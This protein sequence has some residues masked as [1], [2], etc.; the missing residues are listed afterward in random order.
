MIK[1]KVGDLIQ[2]A[3]H[4][5]VTVIAHCCNCF[6]TMKSGIAPLI[7]KSFPEAYFVD[8]NTKKGDKAKLGTLSEA[9]C[10]ESE[11]LVYNLY[12]QFGWWLRK[13][14]KR[15][16]DYEALDKALKMMNASLHGKVRLLDVPKEELRVGLPKIGAGLAG[17]DWK[18]ISKMIDKNLSHWDVTVYVL[19]ESEIG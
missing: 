4:K 2:A 6:N 1:Y 19:K 18:I 8:Q 7:A 3:K 14:G 9:F 11:T 12:G 10:L 16:L 13:Q 17:G 5:E 15:D